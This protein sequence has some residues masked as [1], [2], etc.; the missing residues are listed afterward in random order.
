MPQARRPAAKAPTDV[1]VALLRGINMGGKNRL[2]MKDLA[3]MLAA[4]GC[5]D[6]ETYIQSGNAVFR[7]PA[8]LARKLPGVL[9]GAISKRFGFRVPVVLRSAGELGQVARGNPFLAAGAD[10]ATLHV[11][12]LA[13]LPSASRAGGLDAHRSPPDELAVRGREIYLRLPNGVARSKLTNAWFDS[14]L[15]TTST[16]RSWRTVLELLE[17]VRRFLPV[18]TTRA[19]TAPGAKGAET[20]SSAGAAPGARRGARRVRR[21]GPAPRL[22]PRG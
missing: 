3:A 16:L 2:P 8:A 17:L 21:R 19:E 12:F 18:R 13:G 14:A 4:A 11:A 5:S 1:Q 20:R 15:G 7:A 6:V 9:E 22:P 10:P